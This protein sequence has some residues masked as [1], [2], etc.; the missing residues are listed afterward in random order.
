MYDTIRY[1]TMWYDTI[2]YGKIR[3][4][5]LRYGTIRYDTEYGARRYMVQYDG[6]IRYGIDGDMC[7]LKEETLEKN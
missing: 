7:S 1:D 5:T 4:C 6:M 2:R 3:Y